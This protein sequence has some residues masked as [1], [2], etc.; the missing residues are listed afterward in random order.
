MVEKAKK[1]NVKIVFPIDYVTADKFDKDAKVRWN[2]CAQAMYH[3]GQ[4]SDHRSS[5]QTGYATDAEGIPAGWMGLDTGVK[6]RELY[7]Q[8]VLEAK[9]ILWN[10]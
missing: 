9:T 1:N 6:S 8:A 2:L 4:H 3:R 10:G 7:R 5:L